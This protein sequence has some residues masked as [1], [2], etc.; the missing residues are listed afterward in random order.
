MPCRDEPA[1]MA[2]QANNATATM[3]RRHE[4]SEQLMDHLAAV[5]HFHLGACVWVLIPANSQI[6]VPTMA[7]EM[8]SVT[9]SWANLSLSPITRPGCTPPPAQIEK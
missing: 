8:G 9:G 6:V 4:P 3:R 2:V 1:K 7:G 5:Q